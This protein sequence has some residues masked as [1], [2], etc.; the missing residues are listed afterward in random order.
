LATPSLVLSSGAALTATEPGKGKMMR[1]RRFPRLALFLV[2]ALLSGCAVVPFLPFLPVMGSAY[3]GYVVW[4]SGK[5]TKYFAFDLDMTYR[6]VM[7]ACDQLKIEATLIKAAPKKGY[8]LKTKG[9]VPVPMHI[10]I[11]PLEKSVAVTT[12]VISI[13]MF[14]DKQY[15]ELFYRLVDDNL[16]KKAAVDKERTQ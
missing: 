8:F 15:V 1:N 10:D 11:L 12:V 13:S 6:A 2:A 7:Q 14:G 3:D 16:Y 9:T 4:K 5:A